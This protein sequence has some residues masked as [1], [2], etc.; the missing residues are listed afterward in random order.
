MSV[1]KL[2]S[3]FLTLGYAICHISPEHSTLISSS[4]SVIPVSNIAHSDE[5]NRS[6]VNAGKPQK[7]TKTDPDVPRNTYLRQASRC[8]TKI[9]GL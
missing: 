6:A 3:Y 1:S 2:L 5:E 4:L 7:E 9:F 8:D